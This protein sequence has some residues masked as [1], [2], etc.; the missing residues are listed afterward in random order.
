M[1][2]VLLGS[3]GLV[4]GVWS[5]RVFVVLSAVGPAR[6]TCPGCC[7]RGASLGTSRPIRQAA[8]GALEPPGMAAPACWSCPSLLH[9][10][11]ACCYVCALLGFFCPFVFTQCPF[12]AGDGPC[13]QPSHDQHISSLL[14]LFFF[15]FKFICFRLR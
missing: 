3:L 7:G 2:A 9:V 13:L 12:I 4:L 5:C 14:L 10:F 11:F 1:T 15:C 8:R 6:R